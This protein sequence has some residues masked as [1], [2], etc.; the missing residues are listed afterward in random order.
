[1]SFETIKQ[2]DL[3]VRQ[4]GLVRRRPLARCLHDGAAKAVCA[5]ALMD[6]GGLFARSYFVAA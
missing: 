4:H 5:G 6:E 2:L 1:M 3:L